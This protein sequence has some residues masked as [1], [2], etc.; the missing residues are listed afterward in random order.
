MDLGCVGAGDS[1]HVGVRMDCKTNSPLEKESMRSSY[2]LH[3]YT[4]IIVI[5]DLAVLNE[6]L[7]LQ[8]EAE[9]SAVRRRIDYIRRKRATW[10]R[11]YE[12]VTQKDAL[13]TLGAIEDANRKVEEAISESSREKVGIGALKKQLEDLQ[14]EVSAAHARLHLTQARVES[15]LQRIEELREEAERLNSTHNMQLG[16]SKQRST[17]KRNQMKEGSV[18][19]DRSSASSQETSSSSI[20]TTAASDV[21]RDS[22]QGL[23]ASLELEKDLQNH[24]YPVQFS[25]KLKDDSLLPFEL[26]GEPWVLF[27]DGNGSAACIKDECAH[28]A[29]PLSLGSV[30]NGEIQCPYH[31]WSFNAE[32]SCTAM[33]S[34]VFCKGIGV[35]AL[36][37]VEADGFVFVWPG[38]NE[39]PSSPQIGA[40]DVPQGYQ[41]HAE[42]EV[43]VP[44]DHGL[45]L[46][47]LLDLAHAPFTHTSTFAKGWPIPDIVRF[48][49]TTQVLSG[50][51]QP[52]PIDMSFEP[53][54]MVFSTIGL[55][56][57]GKIERGSRA[58][59]CRNHLHQMHVCLPSRPGHSRLLYRMSMDFLEWTRFIPGMPKVWEKVAGRVL[60]EDLSLVEGQQDRLRRGANTWG[61][62]VAY[63]KLGVKYRRWRNTQGKK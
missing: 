54:C 35:R 37:V 33:P 45:L 29:C 4:W 31:G 10:E 62:P 18:A 39:P 58:A 48:H 15:N 36:P 60:G 11:I 63:D 1:G 14:Q 16:A 9:A 3:A 17:N 52:Y 25:S 22:Y 19:R 8:D 50:S 59:D 6:R 34:T 24:W 2:I 20:S 53:P 13:F 43:E 21:S 47:N 46:E 51:W 55:S 5:A 41:V 30:T 56:K 42:I 57:P 49:Q 32:G 28:R 23:Q 26:L 27:R 12:Y 40:F 7:A 44:V 38:P 61:H